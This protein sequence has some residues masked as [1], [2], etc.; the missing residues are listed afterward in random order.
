MLF[1]LETLV[2]LNI[3]T[4]PSIT[5]SNVRNISKNSLKKC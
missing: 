2:V 4:H 1:F 5:T 3:K